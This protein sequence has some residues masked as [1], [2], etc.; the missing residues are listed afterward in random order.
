MVMRCPSSDDQ[1]AYVET[2][3]KDLFGLRKDMDL[4]FFDE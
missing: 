2:R 3:L 4:G 1:L